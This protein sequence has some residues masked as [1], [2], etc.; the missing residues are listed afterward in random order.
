MGDSRRDA[1]SAED[2]PA[3]LEWRLLRPLLTGGWGFYGLLGA[4]LGVIALGTIAYLTQLAF[5]LGVTGLRNYVSWGVYITNFVFFIGISHAGTLISAILRVTGTEW[6]RPIT[7]MAEAITVFALLLAAPMVIVDLGRPDRLLHIFRYGRIQSPIL[8][9]VISITT[10]LTGSVLYL[11]LPLIPDL[12]ILRDRFR[13]RFP[14]RARL[15]GLLSLGWAGTDEQRRLLERAIGIMAIVIMPVAVSVHTVVSWIFAMTLREGWHS[16]IFGPYFVVGAIFSGIA[17]IITAMAIFRRVYHLE[18]YI[19]PLHFRNLGYL[20]LTLNVIYIYFTFADYLTMI[21][22]SR[23]AET[24]LLSMLFSGPHALAFW[25][26]AVIGLLVPAFLVAI[27]R[28]RTIPGIVI[29]SILINIGLWLKRY[30]IIIPA[31]HSPFLP[32]QGVPTEWAYYRPTWVEWSVTA[33]EF[34]GF[35]LLYA[36]FSKVSPIISIWE[37]REAKAEEIAA[38]PRLR[39]VEG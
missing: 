6:R 25:S 16:S 22:G 2:H 35:I 31:L 33:A 18:E 13:A 38:S 4:L 5:G 3:D 23:E 7:R 27:P 24:R 12:A 39:E 11:Y 34:V 30:V 20:L 17:A 36:L 1:I 9:D 21:Y 14:L 28:T 29:A 19:T 37:T 26:M 32:I 8:W 15:Y 10:Y